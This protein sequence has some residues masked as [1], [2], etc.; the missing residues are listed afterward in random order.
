MV[1][2]MAEPDPLIELL[3][4]GRAG[5]LRA[6][7]AG[8]RALRRMTEEGAHLA[9]TLVDLAERGAEVAIATVAGRHHHG[10][11]VGVGGDYCV[12]WTQSGAEIHIRLDAVSTVR[13][14]PGERH[15]VASGERRPVTGGLLIDVLGRVAGE[16]HR[17]CLV[18]RSG[19]V[20]AGELRGVGADVLSVSLGSGPGDTCYVAAAAVSEASLS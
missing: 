12:L 13:P 5:E 8:E 2:G 6:A 1:K 4:E 14:H 20:V 16:R 10:V 15:D 3:D 18:T 7:R 19:D 17:V 9:G 11:V